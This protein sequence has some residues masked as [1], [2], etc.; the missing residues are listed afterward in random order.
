[1]G[2]LAALA[3]EGIPEVRAGDDLARIVADALPGDLTDGDVVAIAHKVVSKAE[4]R[5]RRLGEIEPSPR[6][7]QLAD[8][9]G[10]DPR[11]VQAVLDE[12]AAIV[13][14]GHGVLVCETHHGFVCANGGVDRSNAASADELILLP[15]DPDASAR[16]IRAGIAERRGVSPAVL[17]TDSFGRAWRVGQTDV[18]LGTA[19]LEPLDDWRGRTDAAGR[20]LRATSIAV[21]DAIAGAAD[22]ARSKDGSLPVVLV[23]GL[24]RLV[25]ADDGPGASPLRRAAADDLFRTG[26]LH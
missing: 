3:I 21:A 11:F 4:G 17:V 9:H 5:V 22:L 1:V 13:G 23:R 7:I 8:E 19:G 25:A 26:R 14:A 16:L 6:A 15:E 10:K 2:S 20:E 18:A 24:E 12:S